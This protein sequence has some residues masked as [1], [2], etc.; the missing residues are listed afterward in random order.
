MFVYQKLDSFLFILSGYFHSLCV[1]ACFMVAASI[2][3]GFS[4]LLCYYMHNKVVASKVELG[5]L[6]TFH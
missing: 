6:C 2:L 3:T 5:T 1:L 4:L